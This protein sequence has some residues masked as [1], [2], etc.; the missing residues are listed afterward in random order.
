MRYYQDWDEQNDYWRREDDH[1]K[2]HTH[3]SESPK[4]KGSAS[5]PRVNDLL[6]HILDKV[7]GLDDL[8]K[9]MKAEFS[10]LNSKVKSHADAIKILEGQLSLLSAQL[11]QKMTMEDDDKGLAVVTCSGKVA[12]ESCS[13]GD[14][15][16]GSSM[17]LLVL[18]AC[19]ARMSKFVTGISETLVKECRTAMLIGEMDF[20]CLVVH[21]QQIEE[22]KFKEMSM[23]V[24]RARTENGNFSN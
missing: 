14:H 19:W 17:E 21:S 11:K 4:S 20:S 12:I 22:E 16:Y 24:K 5:S 9:G 13:Q 15:R 10:S 23:E 6:S 7:E 2:D 18:Q 8:L 3:S 1:E